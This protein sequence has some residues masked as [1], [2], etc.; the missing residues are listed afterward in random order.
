METVNDCAKKLL[1]ALDVAK[2]NQDQFLISRS[3]KFSE[4]ALG[5]IRCVR[6][7]LEKTTISYQ[8]RWPTG[9]YGYHR[10]LRVVDW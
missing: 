1:G 3:A 7:N 9:P 10:N 6:K 8:H 5:R 4:K 2:R